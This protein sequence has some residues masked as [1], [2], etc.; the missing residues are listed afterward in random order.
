MKEKTTLNCSHFQLVQGSPAQVLNAKITK[1]RHR[2]TANLFLPSH[3]ILFFAKMSSVD[4]LSTRNAINSLLL[5]QRVPDKSVRSASKRPSP[6]WSGHWK[7]IALTCRTYCP[8]D[9][10]KTRKHQVFPKT[11]NTSRSHVQSTQ[12]TITSAREQVSI[13]SC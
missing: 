2:P 13:S 11:E 4:A 12:S 3:W 5:S 9:C 10:F 6:G 8:T 1:N 7:T